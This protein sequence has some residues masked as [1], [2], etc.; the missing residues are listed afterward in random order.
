MDADRID[1]RFAKV[2]TRNAARTAAS[3]AGG[4]AT[5][6]E[7]E[8]LADEVARLLRSR[9]GH[10]RLVALRAGRTRYAPAG[11]LGI[12]RSGAAYMTVG[13]GRATG[14]QE[15]LLQ[16]FG[17]GLVVS[18]SGLLPDETPIARTGPYTLA[19]RRTH[20]APRAH[21]PGDTAYVAPAPSPAGVVSHAQVLALLDAA[22]PLL[23]T[24]PEDVW[25]LLHGLG[26]GSGVWELWG[27]LLHGGRLIVVERETAA[28]ALGFARLLASREVTVLTRKPSAFGSLLAEAVAEKV[29][30]PALRRVVLAGEPLIPADVRRWWASGIAPDAQLITT[31]GSTGTAVRVT[32]CPRTPWVLADTAAGRTPIGA[33]AMAASTAGN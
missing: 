26:L 10:G 13:A 15:R 2:A 28:D 4:E 16:D 8:W 31:Y 29:R 1:S 19:S 27:P 14:G 20:P 30:L 3:D 12:L 24:G 5:Y 22:V 9:T 21:L 11:V 6:L 25:T 33:P 18:D 7:L 32:Y 17:V 23:G